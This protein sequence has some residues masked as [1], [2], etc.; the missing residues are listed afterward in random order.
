MN[1]KKVGLLTERQIE[2][3]KL[4]SQ[5]LT[6]EEV[7]KR[8]N[9]T[10]ENVS[11]LEKR[12]YRNIKLARETLTALKNFGVAI[13]VVIKPGTHLVDVPR[14]I[15]NK[16]DE[17]NIKVKANFSR[18]Y[19]EIIFKAGDKVKRTRVIRQIV[20]KILPNGEFTVE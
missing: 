20:V 1:A 18:I 16:A 2:V 5:G 6:Q 4:R 13:P 10:R 3:L 17:A 14:I 15:L 11:I 7:A 19:D 9:T 12:A 8:L